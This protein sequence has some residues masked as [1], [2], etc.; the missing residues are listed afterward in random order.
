MTIKIQTKFCTRV[1][2]LV[3]RKYFGNPLKFLPDGC[4]RSVIGKISI[5][6]DWN[7]INYYYR[8]QTSVLMKYDNRTLN[9]LLLIRRNGCLSGTNKAITKKGGS[10]VLQRSKYLIY[11]VLIIQISTYSYD[12]M[13]G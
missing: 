2:P 12:N 13:D 3:Y 10:T 11:I 9:D 4:I 5:F 1:L 6:P 8:G 7:R